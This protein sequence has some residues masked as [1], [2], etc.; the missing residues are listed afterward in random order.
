MEV[1]TATLI[2]LVAIL[3][4]A[5]PATSAIEFFYTLQRNSDHCFEEHL[6]AQVLMNGE[7]FFDGPGD[8]VFRV[9]NPSGIVLLSRVWD[10]R[11]SPS[12]VEGERGQEDQVLL[13][14]LG[15]GQIQPLSQ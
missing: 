11:L 9:E 4:A 12:G 7:I 15:L 8:L 1:S 5:L 3:A 6:G 13:H 10:W 2:L 14:H